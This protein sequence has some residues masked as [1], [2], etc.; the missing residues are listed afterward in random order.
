MHAAVVRLR[1][2]LRAIFSSIFADTPGI[3]RGS[4]N[5]PG[6]KRGSADTPGIKRADGW[7]C[8]M[9]LLCT[10]LTTSG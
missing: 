10:N 9:V 7:R 8:A 1:R 2:G 5:T 4:A 3:K 6:T